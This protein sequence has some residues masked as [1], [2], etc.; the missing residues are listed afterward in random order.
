MTATPANDWHERLREIAALGA[1]RGARVLGEFAGVETRSGPPCPPDAAKSP[2]FESGVVFEVE[3]ALTGHVAL[4]FDAPTRRSLV[5]LLLD[6][7]EPEA[8]HD[9]VESALCELANIV[10]SQTV[11]AIA[12]ALGSRVTLSVPELALELAPTRLAAA[13]SRRSGG[14]GAAGGLAF[15]NELL[16]PGAELRVLLVIAP[17]A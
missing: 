3:G 1:E 5:R 14:A 7:E 16:A 8:P 6:E 11:S 9:L 4:L 2:V 13:R 15:A 12:D 10:V 17:D